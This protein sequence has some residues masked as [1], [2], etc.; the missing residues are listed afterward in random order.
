M[1]SRRHQGTKMKKRLTSKPTGVSFLKVSKPFWQRTYTS[2]VA[3]R[4]P[5]NNAQRSTFTPDFPL[6]YKKKFRHINWDVL[7][8]CVCARDSQTQPDSTLLHARLALDSLTTPLLPRTTVLDQANASRGSTVCQIRDSFYLLQL[9]S[10][11]RSR[12]GRSH[13]LM[14]RCVTYQLNT[15]RPMSTRLRFSP[16]ILPCCSGCALKFRGESSCCSG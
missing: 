3:V 4:L 9:V 1:K 10:S 14:Q 2:V 12:R 6:K 13:H 16:L 5:Y 7:A 8:Q 15:V 11:S